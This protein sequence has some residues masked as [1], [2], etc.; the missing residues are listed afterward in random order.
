M[1]SCSKLFPEDREEEISAYLLLHMGWQ[2]VGCVVHM[3]KRP[4]D[5]GDRLED[6]LQTFT[7]HQISALTYFENGNTGTMRCN[8]L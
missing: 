6:V 7:V 2:I 1:S 4:I 5:N 3:D 8:E